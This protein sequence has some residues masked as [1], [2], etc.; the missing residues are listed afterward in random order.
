MKKLVFM[1]RPLPGE[2]KAAFKLRLKKLIKTK[3]VK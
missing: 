3:M 2:S 1:I